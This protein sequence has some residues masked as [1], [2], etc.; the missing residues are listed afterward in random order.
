MQLVEQHVIDRKD[1]RYSMIDAAAFKSKNLYNTALYETRQAYIHEGRVISYTDLD[2]LMQPH[3]TYRALP[4]K[5]AQLVLQQVTQA[6]VDFF[7]ARKEYEAHSDKFLGRPKL[8]GY[9]HK[10]EGR[11]V[12]VYTGQAVSRKA[13]KRGLI[14]PSMLPITVTTKQTSIDQVRIVPRKGY[15]VVEVIYERPIQPANLDTALCA[16]IDL[17][18]D[19]L[20]AIASNKRGFVPRLVNGRHLKMLNQ[21]YNKRKAQLQHK[22]GTTGTTKQMERLTT[23]RNRRIQHELHSASKQIVDLLVEEGIGTLIIGKNVGWKQGVEMGRRTDQNFVQLPH[24]RFIDMLTYKA[25]LVGIQVI[26]TEESY[27]SKASFLDLDSLPRYDPKRTEEPIFSGKRVKRG[28]Y[29]A[30]DGRYIHADVNG[31]YNIL[32][33]GKPDAF[34]EA[35]GVAGYV[36]HPVRIAR[37]NTTKTGVATRR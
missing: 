27:T 30:A 21:W 23:K 3:E 35:E 1:P 19:N 26:V 20:A 14:Q 25:K 10:S 31:A 6:W 28:M 16:G 22:L 13:L 36:V 5:V 15:Y 2:K 17:G 37:T 34:E 12:L 18:I 32:R 24:A 8:P 4:A 33:K 7:R 11:N 9:K 29:R